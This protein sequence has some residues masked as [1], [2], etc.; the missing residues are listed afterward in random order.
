MATVL[1]CLLPLVALTAAGETCYPVPDG[2]PSDYTDS[3]EQLYLDAGQGLN[4]NGLRLPASEFYKRLNA[5]RAVAIAETRLDLSRAFNARLTPVADWRGTI[6][7]PQP[8]GVA[9]PGQAAVMVLDTYEKPGL[10][11][12]LLSVQLLLDQAVTGVQL[13]LDG[14]PIGPEFDSTTVQALPA[15]VVVPLDGQR[16]TLS[17]ALPPAVRASLTK[18]ACGGCGSAAPLRPY[19][20]NPEGPT[21]GLSFQTAVVCTEDILCQA[22]QLEGTARRDV[23]LAIYW[24]ALESFAI[25][26]LTNGNH[27]GATQ[28]GGLSAEDWQFLIDR[29]ATKYR[30]VIAY[31]A[32]PEG[33]LGAER[34]GCYTCKTGNAPSM[35]KSYGYNPY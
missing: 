29:Y 22:V 34:S 4:L 3:V 23:A 13:L 20:R 26:R 18:I 21:Q 2:A 35:A 33:G 15:G 10:G 14:Q 19:L 24:K 16:H 6:G 25:D 5:A 9:A 12:R 32:L 8:V 17:V 27:Q 30:E 1:D 28:A 7:K 11:L 31:L